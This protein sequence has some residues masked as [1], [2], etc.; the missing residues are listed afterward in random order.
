MMRV[1]LT[2]STGFICTFSVL[3]L[4]IYEAARMSKQVR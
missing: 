2:D 1:F 3:E 4:I